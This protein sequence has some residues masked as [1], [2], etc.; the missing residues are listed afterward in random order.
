MDLANVSLKETN[1]WV[2]CKKRCECTLVRK[3]GK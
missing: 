3:L 2:G 1:L